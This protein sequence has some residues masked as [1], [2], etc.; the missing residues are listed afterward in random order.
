MEIPKSWK[1]INQQKF[2]FGDF[3]KD[4]VKNIDDPYPF[5]KSRS[6]APPFVLPNLQPN[7]Y[8]HKARFSGGEI[9]LSYALQR[10]E[11]LNNQNTPI[12]KKFIK[13]NPN[14]YGRVKT[15]ASTMDKL[16]KRYYP[17]LGDVSGVTIETNKRIEAQR[18][19]N[20]LKNK[21]N[22]VAGS[23]D[24]YY[25]K[26]LNGVYSAYHLTLKNPPLKN[27]YPERRLEVQ[28]KTHKMKQLHSEMHPV[29]KKG[30]VEKERLSFAK[31]LKRLYSQGY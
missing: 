19:F 25:S 17:Q 7:P 15:V 2:I 14:A 13:D 12:I 4:G 5:D 28:I 23:V 26:P 11:S 6:Q 22:V 30:I 18:K 10:I 16:T 8:Y 31:R 20:Q 1:N 27:G 3:D 24:D 29:F 21:S 9:K